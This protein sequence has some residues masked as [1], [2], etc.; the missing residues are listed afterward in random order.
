MRK[1]KRYE[2][3][4]NEEISFGKI[5]TGI[6]ISTLGFFKPF[7]ATAQQFDD[8]IIKQITVNF[9]SDQSFKSKIDRCLLQS[10][11]WWR[12]RLWSQKTK[13]RLQ[14]F[15]SLSDEETE[16]YIKKYLDLLNKIEVIVFDGKKLDLIYRTSEYSNTAGMTVEGHNNII[17]INYENC[18]NYSEKTFTNLFSHEI[19]HLLDEILQT[20]PYEF[21]KGLYSEY[22]DVD[23][24]NVDA[25]QKIADQFNIN[26]LEASEYSE[27]IA[28]MTRF[29]LK[30]F[31][32][33]YIES[34]KEISARVRDMRGYF[35]KNVGEKIT[36]EDIKN[37][38]R[39]GRDLDGD[40]AGIDLFLAHWSMLGY[41]D[42]ES[43]LSGLNS[44]T[45]Q[46]DNTNRI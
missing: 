32:K 4:V 30:E 26:K 10:K 44:F 6:A 19:Q 37:Y 33:E 31:G 18:K 27:M 35:G 45:K 5:I 34:E 20:T 42:L 24:Q 9:N 28:S 12:N 23:Y 2:E 25:A 46:D 7:T 40:D 43:I 41:P 22:R 14:N 8:K 21:I 17:F 11:E 29:Y 1:L 36:V 16:N 39:E 13:N 3:F 15:H 38:V